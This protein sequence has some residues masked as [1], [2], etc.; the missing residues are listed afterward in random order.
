MTLENKVNSNSDQ[1]KFVHLS[2]KSGWSL[3]KIICKNVGCKT[4]LAQKFLVHKNFGSQKMPLN[5]GSYIILSPKRIKVLKNLGP[6]QIWVQKIICK[7]CRFQKLFV[8]VVGTTKIFVPKILSPQKFL[9]QQIFGSKKCWFMKK[10]GSR[11]V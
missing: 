11:K 9:V 3:T 8:K 2:S 5:F 10:C 7:N 1:F 6:E 4:F